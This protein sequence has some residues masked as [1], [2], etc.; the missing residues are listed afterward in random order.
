MP[1][2][3]GSSREAISANIATE[4]R[5]GKDPKQA[6]AIAYSKARGDAEVQAKAAGIMFVSMGGNALFLRRSGA[7]PDYPGYWDFPGGAQEGNETAEETAAREAREEIGS[8][9]DGKR[10]LHTRTV[11]GREPR[12]STTPQPAEAVEPTPSLELPAVDYSTFLQRVGN[13]FTPD[14]NDEHD[15][16]AWAPL[17]SPPQP[18]HPGCAIA[19]ERV[20]MKELDVA[21]AIAAGRLTSPQRYVNMW[22][23]AIRITGTDIAYRSKYDE[24]VVRHPEHYLNEEFLARCNGLPVIWKHPAKA[25]LDSREFS[26][27]IVGSVFL[28]YIDGDEVWAIAKIWDQPAALAMDS[29][30]LSTSPSVFFDD[31]RVNTKITTDSGR[32]ILI[33]GDPYLLDHVAICDLGVWDKGTQPTGIR[34]ESRE[35]SS[36]T[37][38][39]MADKA[40][41]DAAAEEKEKFERE[42]KARKDAAE[43]KAKA[44]AATAEMLKTAIAD[45]MKTACDA[46]TKRMDEFETREKERED[47]TK[48]DAAKKDATKKDKDE[49][50]EEKEKEEEKA[51]KDAAEVE[52]KERGDAKAKKD[53]EDKARDDANEALRERIKKLEADLGAGVPM[54]NTHPDYAKMA[55]I[56]T[57]A[58]AVLTQFGVG[59]RASEP[60]RGETE[61]AYRRRLARQLQT[62]CEKWK[63][64]DLGGPAFADDAVFGP[65]EADIYEAAQA[66]AARPDSGIP[67]GEMRARKRQLDSGHV[68]IEY[69]GRSPASGW[70]NQFAGATR[71]IHVGPIRATK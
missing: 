60:L 23:F 12:P 45:A 41:K 26:D 67:D 27:R 43:E 6:A 40:K 38:E 70:M 47:A 5:A 8:V 66:A 61:G 21:R 10:L 55:D 65:V 52:A 48:K 35:D 50:A 69:H 31:P 54:L 64:V 16:F 53:A 51:K 44:D 29:G 13:E 37:P 63:A 58:D 11:P 28:P 57:R 68:I 49:S 34:S 71:Q 15:G 9:P 39:M 30:E 22:L 42:D 18:L 46:M 14:L 2:Q 19:L 7:S 25:L 3:E 33:E 62:H 17:G 59:H 56:Q 20:A 1:L 24:F 4:I 36:M 32:T